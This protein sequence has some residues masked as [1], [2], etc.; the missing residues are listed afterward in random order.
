[1]SAFMAGLEV[2]IASMI[3]MTKYAIPA[4]TENAGQCAGSIVN[5][6]S[7][8][9]LREGTLNILYPTSQGLLSI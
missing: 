2:N 3:Q 5:M 8:A 1:M 9:G 6:S 7:V 4:M